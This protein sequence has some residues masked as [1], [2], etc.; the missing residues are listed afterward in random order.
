MDIKSIEDVRLQI[1]N[2][3]SQLV[4]LIAERQKYVSMAAKFKK[5]QAEVR[6]PDR[7]SAVVEKVKVEA[8]N[9]GLSPIVI[10]TIY[11]SMIGAFIEYELE[12]HKEINT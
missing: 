10:E 12:Q 9:N 2:I 5:N 11:R 1:D 7:V 4:K 6:A 8:M 3:D